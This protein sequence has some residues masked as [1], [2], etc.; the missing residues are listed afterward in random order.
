[1]Y[2]IATGYLYAPSVFRNTGA[3]VPDPPEYEPADVEEDDEE[4]DAEE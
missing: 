4:E 1:M 2:L 3:R